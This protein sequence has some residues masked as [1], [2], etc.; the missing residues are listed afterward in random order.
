MPVHTEYS[1]QMRKEWDR[2]NALTYMDA[3]QSGPFVTLFPLPIGPETHLLLAG[4]P[5]QAN[6][7]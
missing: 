7:I 6:A 2:V 1:I 4:G 5:G 3:T